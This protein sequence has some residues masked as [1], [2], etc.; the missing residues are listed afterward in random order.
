MTSLLHVLIVGFIFFTG[1]GGAS[2]YTMSVSH[3][4]REKGGRKYH[5]VYSVLKSKSGERTAGAVVIHA[6]D[7][8]EDDLKLRIRHKGTGGVEI[9]WLEGKDNERVIQTDAA[10]KVF[11][12]HNGKSTP[13]SSVPS[14]SVSDMDK[15]GAVAFLEGLLE[16]SLKPTDKKPAIP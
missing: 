15:E 3:V 4:Y 6:L 7:R 8:P 13:L 5:I 16:E 2:S 11:H 9:V 12:I 10:G 1:C 14:W